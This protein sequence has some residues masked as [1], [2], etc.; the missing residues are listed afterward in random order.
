MASNLPNLYM[1]VTA[2]NLPEGHRSYFITGTQFLFHVLH[3]RFNINKKESVIFMALQGG[4]K[5]KP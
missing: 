1:D 2:K 5:L 3:S 4:K